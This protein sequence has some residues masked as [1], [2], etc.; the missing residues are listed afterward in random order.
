MSIATRAAVTVLLTLASAAVDVTHRSPA[1][2]ATG[3]VDVDVVAGSDDAEESAGGSVSLSSSDLELV[4]DGG[5][6]T[7]GVRFRGVA[8]PADAIVTA[9]W[10]QFTTDEVKSGATSVTIA[11][12]ATDNPATFTRTT[13]NVSSRPRTT[14]SVA[15]SPTPWTVKLER[16]LAQRTPDLSPILREIVARTGWVSGSAVV[17]VITGTG[18]RT[19]GAYNGAHPPSLHVEYTTT[20]PPNQPPVAQAGLDASVRL[21]SSA[22]LTGLATD[23]GLPSPPGA[24][25]TAWSTVSGPALALFADPAVPGTT[26]SFSAP[27]D[28]VLRLSANDGELTATDDVAITVLPVDTAPPT[29]PLDLRAAE[30]AGGRVDLAWTASTDDVAVADY[31]VLRDDALVGTSTTTTFADTTAAP[32]T[33]YAYSVVA[34][35]A[36]GN[37]SD[38][39]DAALVTTSAAQNRVVFSAGGDH[40]ANDRTAASLAALDTSPAEFYLAVG[41]LDYDDTPTD[42]AWCDFVTSH[43]PTKGATFPFELVTGNHE[44]QNGSDGYIMNHAACLPD[45]MASTIGP[46]SVYGAE[47]SFDYPVAQPLMRVIMISPELLIENISYEY[48]AGDPHYQWVAHRIDEAR[49]S[50]IPWVVVGMHHPCYSAG[51]HGCEISAD[52]LNLLVNKRVDLV[53]QGHEHNYERSK[54]LATNAS[55]CPLMPTASYDADC[56]VDDGADASYMKGAGSLFVVAGMFGR[57]LYPI[58]PTRFGYPYFAELDATSWGFVEYTV[59]QDRLQASFVSSS[60]SFTDQ[61]TILPPG[62]DQPPVVEAGPDQVVRLTDGASLGGSVRDDGLPSPPG[63]TSASWSLVTGPGAV[64]FTDPLSPMTI[65]TFSAA[66]TYV[67]RLTGTD[68]ATTLTDDVTITVNAVGLI[69]V[70]DA[71]VRQGSDDAEESAT[72]SIGTSSTD[73]ELVNGDGSDQ[74]VGMRFSALAI[75]AGARVEKAWVQ[76]ETDETKT[77]ATSLTIKGQAADNTSTF[78]SGSFGISSRPTTAASVAWSPPAWTLVH[79]RGPNQRTPDL[80]AIVQE[81]VSR[82]GWT[83]GNALVLVVT[84]TG[85]R[86]AEAYN[87]SAPPVLH[88][89]YTVG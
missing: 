3:V 62:T 49:A 31:V 71:P 12:Q 25:T 82:P 18:V 84:G 80:S 48:R 53:L 5:L 37:T 70:I 88:I 14:A 64:T 67:L 1:S 78:T 87:G 46:G 75:P 19:A 52:L 63:A 10:I 11:G 74:T 4:Y 43:L 56:V 89:E 13:R 29:A 15:W 50:G 22:E 16:G 45:R 79:E 54:Q 17:F 72:G 86:T 60:G 44:D 35:D 69:T 59:T 51:K 9:A 30:A 81:I 68:G 21:P 24:L 28:Y 39:S 33:T 73:L 27:G 23:D 8:V 55:T 40:G 58:D 57:N 36:A 20:P 47:Y 6:Q 42:A 34:R 77:A 38:P 26:A 2:A 32:S 61:F 7:V 66:G 76:F 65:A 41:D 85:V 83:A